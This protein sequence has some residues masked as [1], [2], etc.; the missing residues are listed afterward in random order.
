MDLSAQF[1]YVPSTC[2]YMSLSILK[3]ATRFVGQPRACM[4]M[5]WLVKLSPASLSA[6]GCSPRCYDGGSHEH[7]AGGN[8]DRT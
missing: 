5:P 6:V 1:S 8:P 3:P 4:Q 7:D 2:V